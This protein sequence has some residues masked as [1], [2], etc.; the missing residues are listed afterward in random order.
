MFN[1]G[2]SWIFDYQSSIEPISIDT[3]ITFKE[4]IIKCEVQEA[5]R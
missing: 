5:K 3:V 4:R 1:L 2:S